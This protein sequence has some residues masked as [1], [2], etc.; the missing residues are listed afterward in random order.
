MALTSNR[1]VDHYVDQELRSLPVAASKH[2]YK[3]ALLGVSSTGFARPLTAGDPFAGIAF[4]EQD[5]S[6]GADGDLSVRIYTLGDFGH[7]LSGVTAADIGRPAFASADDALTF[8]GAGNSY[9]GI[10]RDVPASNQ[11][12]LRIDTDRGLVKTM[13]HAVENL[14]AGQDITTR[15]IHAFEADGWAVSARIVNQSTT[16]AGIDNSNT[17]VVTLATGAGTLVAT[18]FDA[19]NTFPAANQTKDM[20]ALGNTHVTAGSVM[21][22]AVTN[23]TSANPGPFTVELDYV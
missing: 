9:V 11:V 13:S 12:L 6:S 20:G 1:E 18:T 14:S 7:A 15:G 5:N 21:T 8:T 17:C 10:V 19:T 3:G 23:A 4:E 16:A 22:L 2:V